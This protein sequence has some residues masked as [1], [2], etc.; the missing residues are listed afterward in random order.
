MCTQRAYAVCMAELEA[1]NI[2]F[3]PEL[4]AEAKQIA[5]SRYEKMSEVLRRK[6]VEY[7]TENQK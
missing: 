7:V 3:P 1:H 6:L 2:K 4:W 5:E